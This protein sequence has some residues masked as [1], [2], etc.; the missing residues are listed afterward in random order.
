MTADNPSTTRKLL[1]HVMIDEARAELVI[2]KLLG[3][4]RK[5]EFPYGEL[6]ALPQTFIPEGIR[7][8]PLT[9]AR[10]LFYCCHYMRGSI[11]S[12]FAVRQ[13]VEIWKER[14]DFFDPYKVIDQDPLTDLRS[15]LG[16]FLMY[17]VDEMTRF[18]YENSQR[19]VLHWKGDPR[20]IFVG[21]D[22]I[23]QL[24]VRVT[25]K[26][27][28]SKHYQQ[29][30]I[31]FLG[32]QEKMAAMLAYFL[33]DVGLVPEFTAPP[34]VDFHLIR[35]MLA[36]GILYRGENENRTMRYE[37]AEPQGRSVLEAYAHRHNVGLV[38]LGNS[39][40]MLSVVLCA[41]APGNISTGR[42]KGEHG[43][44]IHPVPMVVSWDNDA[45]VQA[46][47]KTC[48]MCPVEQDCALNV[49]SGDYYQT[50]ALRVRA[51]ERPHRHLLDS[52][53]GESLERLIKPRRT[54]TSSSKKPETV[55][56]KPVKQIELPFDEG[57]PQT[58]VLGKP[59]D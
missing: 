45:H 6:W 20:N 17:K 22:T 47:L 40:W 26:G 42:M 19:L 5:K 41:R 24:H 39:L 34:P 30:Q 37:H 9:H 28:R 7:S 46:Y 56:T 18:W 51:R 8:N 43:K 44:K 11:K 59:P 36:T 12:D 3:A 2:G 15:Y 35:V 23:S 49:F 14:P 33:I 29:N 32:F 13:L 54:P 48:A 57:S 25:N 58:D 55:S 50:G 1:M 53:F 38:E 27:T 21:V 10:F 31:G 16:K 52:F 4:F